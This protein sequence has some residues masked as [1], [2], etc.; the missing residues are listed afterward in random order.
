MNKAELTARMAHETGFTKADANRALDAFVATV[1]RGLRKGDK[2]TLVG[3]GTF[4]IYRRK[5]RAGRDPQTGAP[6]R[7]NS[8][9]SVRFAAGKDLKKAIR[10]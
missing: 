10:R 7:I 1:T 6:I 2:I 3:F 4:S 8:R 9:R 5:A